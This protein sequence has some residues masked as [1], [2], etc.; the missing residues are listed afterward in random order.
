MLLAFLLQCHLSSDGHLHGNII[1]LPLPNQSTWN[2][3]VHTLRPWVT[4]KW[5]PYLPC[6]CTRGTGEQASTSLLGD[7]HLTPK[8]TSTYSACTLPSFFRMTSLPLCFQMMVGGSELTTSHTITASSPSLN[9]WGVGAF[10]NMSF[11]ESNG[12]RKSLQLFQHTSSHVPNSTQRKLEKKQWNL[13]GLVLQKPACPRE[14][15]TAALDST[16]RTATS[17]PQLTWKQQPSSH[18]VFVTHRS[19][20]VHF[21]LPHIYDA[22]ESSPS[23]FC[24]LILQRIQAVDKLVNPWQA[25]VSTFTSFSKPRKEE[26]LLNTPFWTAFLPFGNNSLW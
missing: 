22:L 19:C 16:H 24:S 7:G 25:K 8:W 4:F 11:S 17:E 20:H 9:S 2:N 21:R 26:N 1:F 6:D 14:E 13:R 10:L 18:S 3:D 15:D 5:L 23:A 12:R